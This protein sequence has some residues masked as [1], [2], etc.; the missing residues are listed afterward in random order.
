MSLFGMRVVLLEIAY[1]LLQWVLPCSSSPSFPEENEGH[2]YFG[3][4]SSQFP[5]E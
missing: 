4:D 2:Q 5:I 1:W 3:S